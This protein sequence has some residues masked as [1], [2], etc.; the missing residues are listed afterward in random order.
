MAGPLERIYARMPVAVQELMVSAQGFRLGKERY[1]G[2]YSQYFKD[3]LESQWWSADQLHDFQ[4]RTLQDLLQHAATHVP[5]YR[6]SFAEAGFEPGDLKGLDDLSRLPVTCKQDVR[7]HPLEFI[8]ERLSKDKLLHIRTSGTTGS[9]LTMYYTADERRHSYALVDRF[10]GWGGYKRGMPRAHLLGRMV[11]PPSQRKPPFWRMDRVNRTLLFSSYHLEELHLSSYLGALEAAKPALI[12]AYPS[13][14]TVLA[15]YAV[16]HGGC[17]VR[18]KTIVTSSETLLDHQREVIEEAF[19]CP[20]SDMYGCVEMAVLIHQC[21]KGTYHECPEYGIV[22]YLPQEG[23]EAP[24][25]EHAPRRVVVTGFICR[26]MP[27]IRYQMGDLAVPSGK[28]CDCGRHFR[29][30]EAIEGRMDDVIV[31]PSGRRVGRMGPALHALGHAIRE[32]QF[33]QEAPD[34]VVIRLV[35]TAAYHRPKDPEALIA[36]AQARLGTDVSIAVEEVKSIEKTP[37]GKLRAI[38]SKVGR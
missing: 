20:V 21:E 6:R 33:V 14:L 36:A 32:C 35:P 13:S 2:A 23:I 25:D 7:E 38:V 34:R 19:A 26:A 37:G 24:A 4:L 30:V 3:A 28:P 12:Y 31:T 11:A 1:G 9:P 29:T 16:R 15:Q 5:W 27:L 18:P 10:M 8:D 22:E 17:R